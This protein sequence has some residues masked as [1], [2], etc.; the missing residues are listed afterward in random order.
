[1]MIHTLI[2]GNKFHI[3]GFLVGVLV[4]TA[5]TQTASAAE[6][7]RKFIAADTSKHRVAIIDENGKTEWEHKI[8]GL[9]DLHVLPGGHVLLQTSWTEVAE[10]NPANN[11]TVWHYDAMK[12]PENTGK[13]LEIHAF[14]R[15]ANGKTVVAE[16]GPGNI[17]ELDNDLTVVH[18]IALKVRKPDA[19]RDTRLVRKLDSGNYL[20]CHEGDG[21][22]RE[23]DP[24][25]K[26]VWEYAVPLFDRQRA[27]GHGVE[28]FG[29][30][31]FSA[32]RLADGNTLIGTGNG[33]S[34]L[35]VTPAEQ[36][37]WS[38]HQNELPG[39]QLAWITSLQVLPSGNIL[40]NNCH[41]GPDNPQLI[42]VN[43]EKQV[44]WSFKDFDRFGNSLTN[45]QMLSV[46]GVAIPFAG[47]KFLR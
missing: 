3:P 37:I 18:S 4:A 9:H 6:P 40:I 38:L 28:A 22:V 46:D 14:Q 26:T 43:R 13:R 2:R 23:Y 21:L 44:V 32:I 5:F 30:Q 33:H 16:S 36:I 35:E 11:E 8:A 41:A 10:I 29:N 27:D 45:S 15:L 34:I 42:E 25:C 31:C 17:I 24:S 39:I 12:R 20:V 1:M 7:T 19:H 47:P